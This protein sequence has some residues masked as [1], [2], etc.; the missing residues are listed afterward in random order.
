M[1][2]DLR[3][4]QNAFYNLEISTNGPVT[5][6]AQ[7]NVNTSLSIRNGSMTLIADPRS[8]HF[9]WVYSPL[10]LTQESDNDSST[11]ITVLCNHPGNYSISVRV[12]ERHCHT[13]E[14]V[15]GGTTYLQV[16]RSIVGK[17]TARQVGDNTTSP[18]NGFN[19]ATNS[20]VQLSFKIHD[21][22]HFLE[23][24]VFFYMWTFGDGTQMVTADHVAHHNYS[25][26]GSSTETRV[27][28]P[29]NVSLHF[30][31]SPPLSV[32]WMIKSDC[33]FL[34]GDECHPVVI[35]NTFLSMR[36]IFNSAGYYCLSIR[37]RNDVSVLQNYHSI[38]VYS[39]GIHPVWFVLPC[40]AL[41]ALAVVFIFYFLLR[42]DTASSHEKSPV[43]VADFDFS[44]LNEEYQALPE[45]KDIST[46]NGCCT[47]C[48]A[49][50]TPDEREAHVEKQPLLQPLS[51]SF[52]RYML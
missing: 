46:R 2:Q 10:L 37:A 33:V 19:L 17:I 23:S 45:Y 22:S 31:G 14:P 48:T 8:Y 13:C 30:F 50:I 51:S 36:H 38:T 27:R 49:E 7:A 1:S 29:F 39:S 5:S 35:N 6:G 16:T 18:R 42:A 41:I 25:R 28:E 4:R 11:R 24:A 12:T 40:G 26:P 20:D 21:P 9:H 34:D 32:C 44:P 3:Q 15:A 52:K 47:Y 43:E